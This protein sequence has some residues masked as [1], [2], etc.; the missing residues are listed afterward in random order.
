[1]NVEAGY[2]VALDLEGDRVRFAPA[3]F[4]GDIRCRWEQGLR[5]R[6]PL[7]LEKVPEGVT[8]VTR[9]LDRNQ[10]GRVLAVGVSY[11]GLLD[12]Q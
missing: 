1:L 7:A 12:A 9:D 11:P 4:V 8:R 2:F 10:L 6:Q 3:N 5:F